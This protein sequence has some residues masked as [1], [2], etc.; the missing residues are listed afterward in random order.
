MTTIR[1][2]YVT[3]RTVC[4]D[5]DSILYFFSFQN[6]ADNV[7]QKIELMFGTEQDD[8]HEIAF[9]ITP[10]TP[11]DLC[12]QKLVIEICPGKIESNCKNGKS[13]KQI[14]RTGDCKSC[15]NRE[16]SIS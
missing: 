16:T 9:T 6:F 15:W 2:R 3:K 4:L 12:I 8:V 7:P 10:T 5:S 13:L 14:R 1:R 11:G